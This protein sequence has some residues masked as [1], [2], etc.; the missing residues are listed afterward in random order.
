M[1]ALPICTYLILVRWKLYNPH[2]A[3]VAPKAEMCVTLR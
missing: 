2:R 1:W 3:I